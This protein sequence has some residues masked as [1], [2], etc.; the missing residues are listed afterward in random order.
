MIAPDEPR[1]FVESSAELPLVSIM[2]GFR[3]GAWL[4]PPGKEGLTRLTVRMLRRGVAGMTSSEVEAEIDRIGAELNEHAGGSAVSLHLD[5]IRRSFD[6]AVGLL[7]RLLGAPTFDEAELGKLVRETE[8]E[9]VEA[10]NN[11]RVLC[12]RAF[13][14]TLFQ[15]HPLSRRSIGS[16]QSIGAIT[17]DDVVAHWRKIF[18][19]GNFVLGVAG[20]IDEDS[21]R[22]AAHQLHAALPGDEPAVQTMAD[23]VMNSGRRLVFVDK[24]ERTQTQLILGCLGTRAQDDDHTALVVA[25]TVFGGIFTSRLMREVRTKRGWSY[26][27][28]SSLPVDV[29]REAFSVWTHP[30]A[31]DAAACLKLE[32]ELLHRW[33]EQGITPRELAAAKHYLVRSHAFEVDTVSKRVY[34]HVSQALY[35][36]PAD[37]YSGYL[38]RVRAVTVEHANAAVS[39]RIS[40]D[41]L[42]VA[43][44]G[45]HRDI[46]EQVAS[47]IPNLAEATMVPYDLE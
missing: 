28:Y 6:A 38:D 3:A 47:A 29:C 14:R 42:V 40:N 39:H 7:S 41:S 20:D 15:N 11:D 1:V 43:I 34:R 19:R 37:Y 24:P 35:G 10:R 36:L 44:T 31:T 17:R 33:R 27:A 25:N 18:T 2:L 23:P 13:R 45:T 26:G 5:V 21:A 9:I 4:D 46:G 22:R 32:L 16:L 30:S 12:G 8:G